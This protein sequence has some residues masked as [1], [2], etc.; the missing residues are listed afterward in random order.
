MTIHES[1]YTH[2]FRGVG[3]FYKEL[4]A[5]QQAAFIQRIVPLRPEHRILDLACG[6]GRHTIALAKLGYTVVGYD[7]SA[8]YIA[9][10]LR[11][12][13]AAEVSAT[14]EQVDMRTL[15]LEA[16]FDVVLSMSTSL[17]FFDDLTNK[18]LFR[19]IRR[20]LKPGGVFVFDQ[21]NIFTLMATATDGGKGS[22]ATLP[23]GRTCERRVSFDA[24]RC[25]LSMRSLL[26][27]DQG[28]AESG[29]DIR[30]YTLPEL[31]VQLPDAG[32]ELREYFG[33]YDGSPFAAKSPRLITVW[34]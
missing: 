21:G 13:Q 15:A 6:W 20:S 22:T 1:F 19:R 10:A 9:Q 26:H 23:D 16:A 32:F 5:P 8:D 2:R 29:W 3:Q 18:D 30:Y 11:D 34:T 14:F 31:R 17:A 24:G 12:A 25:V 28:Q 33:D 27:D 4:E 7:A